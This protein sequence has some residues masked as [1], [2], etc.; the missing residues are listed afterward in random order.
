MRKKCVILTTPLA[1]TGY[2]FLY[3][4]TR[5]RNDLGVQGRNQEENTQL[6]RATCGNRGGGW[7][8]LPVLLCCLA[9]LFLTTQPKHYKLRGSTTAL[10]KYRV[11]RMHTHM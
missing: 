3:E 8:P 11:S 6:D 4:K 5:E 7:C 1:S 9:Q 10:S 2:N